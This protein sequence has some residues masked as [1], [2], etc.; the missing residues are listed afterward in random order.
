MNRKQY[1]I[2]HRHNHVYFSFI[3][4]GEEKNWRVTHS[5]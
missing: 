5:S 3:L 4:S 2:E 1:K